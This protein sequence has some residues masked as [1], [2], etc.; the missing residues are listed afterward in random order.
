MFCKYASKQV[1]LG[2][3]RNS[4]WTLKC[5]QKCFAPV[6][7]HFIFSLF[8]KTKKYLMYII[9]SKYLVWASIKTTND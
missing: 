5:D 9:W 6:A 1:L 3:R 2:N 8:N 7:Y 4:T